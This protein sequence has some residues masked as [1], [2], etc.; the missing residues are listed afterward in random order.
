MADNTDRFNEVQRIIYDQVAESA[1]HASPR[2]L[3]RLAETFA[4]AA[5]PGQSHGSEN[6]SS[7]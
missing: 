4:W 5:N 7:S 2:D 1:P 6:S 3:L